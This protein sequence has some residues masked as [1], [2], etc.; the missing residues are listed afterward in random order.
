MKRILAF[1]LTVAGFCLAAGPIINPYRFAGGG[2][3]CP[4]DGTPDETG[5]G[6]DGQ[7]FGLNTDHFRAGVKNWS[8]GSARSICK[9]GL[10]IASVS[11]SITAF[12]YYCTIYT[13]S[14][15]NLGTVVAT[16]DG[17]T[18]N[19]SWGGTIV[20]FTFASPVALSASTNY[21]ITF[22]RNTVGDNTVDATN[23]ANASYLSGGGGSAT[24]S[25]ATWNTSGVIEYNPV[26]GIECNYEVYFYD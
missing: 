20:R 13:V 9:T 16:S 18:G 19:D 8:N 4:A 12:T 11:G 10:R 17:Q 3:S 14:G 1:I 24:G 5:S 21:H 2:A 7:H 26:D 22:H 23:R 6:T 25:F 15:N